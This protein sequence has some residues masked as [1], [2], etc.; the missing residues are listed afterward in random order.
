MADNGH[1]TAT[2]LVN[3]K[4]Q[5]AAWQLLASR[6]AP[7]IIACLKSLF[8]ARD[9]SIPV[10]QMEQSLA[11]ML[12]EYAN[13]EEFDV[14]DDYLLDARREI[15]DW[16]RRRLVIERDGTLIATDDLQQALQF[17]DGIQDRIMTST[18]SRLATVQ[19]EIES[20]ATRLNADTASREQALIER[21]ADL[22]AELERVRAGEFEVLEGRAAQEAVREVYDLA[23]SLRADFRRVEDSFREADRALRQ[24]II[25]EGRHRGEIVDKLLDNH[26]DLLETPEGQ[27][28]SG[29]HQQL[30]QAVELDKMKR[31][32]KE[33]ARSGAAG[34][35][36]NRNQRSDMTW[37]I[38]RL[39]AE[40]RGVI[41]ARAA[42]E[43][44]V[45]GFIKT[46]LAAEHHRVGQLLNDAFEAA[47]NIDWSRQDIR[48]TPT[49][50]PVVA[51]EAGNLPM[52]ERLRWKAIETESKETL[53]LTT[54]DT[55]LEDI[56]DDFWASLDTLDRRALLEQTRELL[57]R[58][59]EPMSV[60]EIAREIEPTHDLETIAFWLSLAREVEAPINDEVESFDI[61]A[62]EGTPLRFRV[63]RVELSGEAL[64]RVSWEGM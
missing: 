1:E 22:E 40:S 35:A 4:R 19:R 9:A 54:H 29:F 7:L 49:P 61:A 18:A 60:G 52:I 28:F 3:L 44:D 63:P 11:G 41:R 47:L 6:R 32:L 8:D 25:S 17:V 59:G 37:L 53:S 12:A 2:N 57:V 46:G 43:R 15:R 55:H 14:G 51:V 16:I 62:S 45:K 48:R 31:R 23:M 36:L 30:T 64:M 27:T 10:D 42:S 26:D 13:S 58:R 56:D 34:E 20:V 38:M 39:V 50:L 5:N 24:S 33:V 21:I